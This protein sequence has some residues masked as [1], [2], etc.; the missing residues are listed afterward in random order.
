MD[1]LCS[2]TDYVYNNNKKKTLFR[3]AGFWVPFF[4]TIRLENE[5]RCSFFFGVS[6]VYIYTIFE[7]R[8]NNFSERKLNSDYNLLRQ[9]SYWFGELNVFF[10]P[11]VNMKNSY[12]YCPDRVLKDQ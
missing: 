5:F 11:N 7:C 8:R 4:V 2:L 3:G 12:W 6:S 10:H 1:I 9:F